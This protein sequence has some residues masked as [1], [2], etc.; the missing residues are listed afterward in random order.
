MKIP[1]VI[2]SGLPR[3]GTSM[4]MNMLAA[5]GIEIATDHTRQADDDNPQGYYEL[6]QVKHLQTD[7]RWMHYMRGKAV[8]VVSSLLYYVPLS[9]PYKI[10]FMRRQIDEILASQKK[11]L[12]RLGEDS[13]TVSDDVVRQKFETHLQTIQ[14][15]IAAR[16]NMDCLYVDYADI[17]KDPIAGSQVVQ[18]F[19]G[20]PLQIEAMAA[21]VDP[22]LYRNRAG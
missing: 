8:K 9:L 2:V 4:M 15:W 6:E 16:K 11:M 19:L 20:Q 12:D 1:V 3:S 17:L 13:N 21:I 14:A 18:A 10:I 22:D 5:G 7:A